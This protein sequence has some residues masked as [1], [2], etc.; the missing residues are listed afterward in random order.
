MQYV[1]K[2]VH[3]NINEVQPTKLIETKRNI[4]N[5]HS[6]I[7][8]IPTDGKIVHNDVLKQYS[9]FIIFR[10]IR[11][12]DENIAYIYEIHTHRNK[13]RIGLGSQLLG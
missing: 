1:I 3:E 12:L 7:L 6:F 13:R 10:L 11:E 5:P 4:E 9:A 2:L 8:Y